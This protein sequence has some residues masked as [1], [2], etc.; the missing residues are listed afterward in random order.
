MPKA[1][2][3]CPKVQNIAQSGH[4][5]TWLLHP[6]P[7]TLL[8]KLVKICLGPCN[9]LSWSKG[10]THIGDRHAVDLGECQFVNLPT[11]AP[12]V[13]IK[14]KQLRISHWKQSIFYSF[15]VHYYFPMKYSKRVSN[16]VK[17]GFVAAN[18][19]FCNMFKTNIIYFNKVLNCCANT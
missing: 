6:T 5:G 14:Y 19:A 9:I 13:S 15:V 1:L 10:C 11:N 7:Q 17:A 18:V 16:N 2:K 8:V 4:T 12:G 3:S